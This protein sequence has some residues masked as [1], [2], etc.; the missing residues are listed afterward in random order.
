MDKFK[1]F[2]RENF[3]LVIII[4]TV[5]ASAIA[6]LVITKINDSQIYQSET[7]VMEEIPYENKKYAENEYQNI[8]VNDQDIALRYFLFLRDN[9][10]NN[11]VVIYN[12]LASEEKSKYESFKDFE[13]KLKGMITVFTPA[14][15]VVKYGVEKINSTSR[16]Y[17]V[18]DSESNSYTIIENGVWNIKF[19][20]NGKVDLENFK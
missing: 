2:V 4:V 6:Y 1:K 19:K 3:V 18:V 17:V 14:N 9:M 16:T 12:M 10:I 15:Q 13:D 8:V 11:P 20:F 7:T 5:V